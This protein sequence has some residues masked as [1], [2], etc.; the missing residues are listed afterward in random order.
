MIADK[1][2]PLAKFPLSIEIK[3][4]EK[5]ID[6][7]E[8]GGEC[9]HI[10]EIIT[11]DGPGFQIPHPHA[12][13]DFYNSY[14]FPRINNEKDNIFY[15]QPRFV[16]HLDDFAIKKVKSIFSKFLQPNTKILDLMSGWT[17][18][19]PTIFKKNNIVGLGLCNDE[20]KNNKD[21][22]DYIIH[23]LNLD[24]HL[25]FIKNEFNAV[26]CTSSIE[27]LIQPIEVT[28]EVVRILKPGGVFIITISD[29]WFNGKEILI[30]SELHA[31]E[32]LGFVLD[33]YLKCGNFNNLKTITIRGFPRPYNDKHIKLK[34]TSDPIF[35]V[36]GILNK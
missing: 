24:Y 22:S 33:L 18:H 12:T 17:S 1:N 5:L 14:P 19:I 31:F 25:P 8:R 6:R 13:T 21:L 16:N 15:N 11:K 27:Y 34:N 29:R 10:A 20:L 3:I 23:D 30:W 4:I 36:I 26:I 2:H 35:A 28:K 9:N 32:R 7:E